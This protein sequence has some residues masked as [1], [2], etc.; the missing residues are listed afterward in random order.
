MDIV[1][2]VV[3]LNDGEKQKKHLL[4]IISSI[5]I[6]ILRLFRSILEQFKFSPLR[7]LE[8]NNETGIIR[9][10]NPLRLTDPQQITRLEDFE[11]RIV[12]YFRRRNEDNTKRA[13]PNIKS[14]TDAARSIFDKNDEIPISTPSANGMPN[15]LIF[16]NSQVE[17]DQ[18]TGVR[19]ST[20]YC[21]LPIPINETSSLSFDLQN[22]SFF[23]STIK[24]HETN[25]YPRHNYSMQTIYYQDDFGNYHLT[26]PG[27]IS[28]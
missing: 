3:I 28:F 13:V 12:S 9:L 17:T 7:D 24:N 23:N 1:S 15:Q 4:S 27:E 11:K 26:S 19:L 6:T 18:S 8:K 22:D 20:P 2:I 16:R 21:D 14:E 5:E 10:A 25:R